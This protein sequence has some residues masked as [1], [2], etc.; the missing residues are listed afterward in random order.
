MEVGCVAVTTLP[1]EPSQRLWQEM[2]HDWRI[3]ASEAAIVASSRLSCRRIKAP[4]MDAAG[5]F[6]LLL[7]DGNRKTP[8]LRLTLRNARQP[9]SGSVRNE[10]SVPLQG[11]ACYHNN[12]NNNAPTKPLPRKRV[13]I[14]EKSFGL[15]AQKRTLGSAVP[16]GN[17]T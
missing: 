1:P 9:R 11:G 13:G 10:P 16:V 2:I 4:L 5:R 6:Q 17:R 15:L 3:V 7:H 14:P 8:R 12:N